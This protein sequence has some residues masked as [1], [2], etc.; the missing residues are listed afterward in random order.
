MPRYFF[1]TDDGDMG[2]VDREGQ[3]LAD[4]AAARF[5]ALHSLSDMLREH[6]HT[7]GRQVFSTAVRDGDGKIVFVGAVA[8]ATTE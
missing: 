2:L 4:E 7:S 3:I 8:L 5:A 6:V 1:D